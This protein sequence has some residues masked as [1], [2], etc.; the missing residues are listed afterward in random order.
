MSQGIRDSRGKTRGTTDDR[1]ASAGLG[2]GT[3]KLLRPSEFQLL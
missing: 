2:R 3:N 1:P